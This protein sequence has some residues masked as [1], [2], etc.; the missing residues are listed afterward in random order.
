[1]LQKSD[2]DEQVTQE[3][4]QPIDEKSRRKKM[5]KTHSEE[6]LQKFL[7]GRPPILLLEPKLLEYMIQRA[8]YRLR[9]ARERS[10]KLQD[11][12]I[13]INCL[14]SLPRFEWDPAR[15]RLHEH[16]Q[17]ILSEHQMTTQL[18][19][20]LS[21]DIY[22]KGNQRLQVARDQGILL[23]E[24]RIGRDLLPT[25]NV[26]EGRAEREALR[27]WDCERLQD[28]GASRGFLEPAD[29]TPVVYTEDISMF[30]SDGD[31][32]ENNDDEETE[33]PACAE[34]SAPA[35]EDITDEQPGGSK[36]VIDDDHMAAELAAEGDS[37][38]TRVSLSS[39]ESTLVSSDGVVSVPNSIAGSVSDVSSAG[40][41]AQADGDNEDDAISL[42]NLLDTS[43]QYSEGT[44]NILHDAELV[45]APQGMS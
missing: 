10:L 45:G 11:I 6:E 15:E 37:E 21:R 18:G 38:M 7:A 44:D 34:S 20:L 43:P 2:E 26:P 14:P 23:H 40:E 3:P 8:N 12:T 32:D 35:C 27:I 19:N 28:V 29:E 22:A 30:N 33:D 39:A 16:L 13:G 24:V 42:L 41:D 31:D 9:F 4:L 1:M 25:W 36:V 17:A 5:S